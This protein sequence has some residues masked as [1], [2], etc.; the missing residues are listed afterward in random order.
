MRARGTLSAIEAEIFA[1]LALVL[2]GAGT[3][4]S[5]SKRLLKIKRLGTLLPPNMCRA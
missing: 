2:V 3:W 4:A 5:A 1:G